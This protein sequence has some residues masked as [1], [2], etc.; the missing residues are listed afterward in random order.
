M[1]MSPSVLN[2]I[3]QVTLTLVGGIVTPL[4][5]P[6]W[7]GDPSG[8]T[9][10]RPRHALITV[11]GANSVRWG[12]TPSAVNGTLVAPGAQAVFMDPVA[13][14]TGVLQQIQFVA[15]GGPATL[16]VEYFS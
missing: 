12:P 14:F 1:V 2:L 3:G 8:V 9:R 5:F 16:Q 4:T 13:D 7:S 15:I 10:I 6:A 11:E